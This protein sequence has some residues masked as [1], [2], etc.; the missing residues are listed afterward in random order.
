MDIVSSNAPSWIWEL[1]RRRSGGGIGL[2]D[3]FGD[4]PR[5]GWRESIGVLSYGVPLGV[6][7]GASE[8]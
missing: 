3:M 8:A 7:S 4:C 5:L 1:I 6:G 2:P